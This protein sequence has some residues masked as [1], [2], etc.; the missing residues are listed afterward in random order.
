MASNRI[1]DD[2]KYM[3]LMGRYKALRG[4]LGEKAMPYLEAAMNLREKGN[5][6]DDVVQGSAML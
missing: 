6:S 5:V 3:A 1:S 4:E 2:E